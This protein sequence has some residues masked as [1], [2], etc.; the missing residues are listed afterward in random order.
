MSRQSTKS[1]FL[2]VLF[3]LYFRLLVFGLFVALVAWFFFRFF[4]HLAHLTLQ[5]DWIIDVYI[6]DRTSQVCMRTRT[7]AMHTL[8]IPQVD[9]FLFVFVEEFEFFQS[10]GQALI[11]WFTGPK[12]F[13]AAPNFL[14]QTKN[15]FTY[16]GSHKHFVPDKK[17]ICIQ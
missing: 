7:F 9:L 6:I 1:S 10:L 11:P 5:N 12:K 16:C 2:N 3:I 17:V 15:L 13:W 8:M 4:F 14:C